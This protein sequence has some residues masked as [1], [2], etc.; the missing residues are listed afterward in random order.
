MEE[1]EIKVGDVVTYRDEHSVDHQALVIHV[2]GQNC[3]NVV[4]LS[5]DETK[6][7]SWGRQT[8]RASSVQRQSEVTAQGRYFTT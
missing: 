6:S 7:D 1:T 5:D 4:Y 3:I 2:H 8:E